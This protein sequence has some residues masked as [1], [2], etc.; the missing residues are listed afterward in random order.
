MVRKARQKSESGIYHIILR[1]IN[2]QSIFESDEDRMKYLQTLERYKELCGYKIYGY[3]LMSNHI[4]LLIETGKEPLEQIMKKISVSYVYWYNSKYQ[5]C[6]HLFQDRYKSEPVEKEEYLLIVLRYIHQN[7]VKAHLVKDIKDYK[8]S[9][10]QEYIESKGITDRDFIY[11]IIHENKTMALDE[12]IKFM[13]ELNEDKCLEIE[14]RKP[15]ITD[16]QLKKMIE[17]KYSIKSVMIQN[18]PK[19]TKKKILKEILKIEG[20]STRQLARVTGISPNVIWTL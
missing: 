19:E 5:R 8:W 17:R 9:S 10:Y 12:F 7:P 11:E 16:D 13:N 14:E 20:V 6:G 15:R 1:G 2:K 18:E 4:H 3:C